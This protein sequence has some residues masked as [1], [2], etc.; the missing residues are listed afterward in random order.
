MAGK[1]GPAKVENIDSWFGVSFD[2]SGGLIGMTFSV[3]GFESASAAKDQFGKIRSDAPPGLKPA[4]PPIG[5]ISV[6]VEANTQ[7]IGGMLV[8]VFRDSLVSLHTA[9]PDGQ[10]P[11]LSLDDLKELPKMVA[12]RL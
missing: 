3:I 9:Q 10:D 2:E 1:V 6:E 8:F 12:G 4:N 11:L 7:E 5:D